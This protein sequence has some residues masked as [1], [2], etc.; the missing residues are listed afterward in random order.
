MRQV[1]DTTSPAANTRRI[2]T[3][4]KRIFKETKKESEPKKK[5]GKK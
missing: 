4:R 2:P 5:T 3:S 1:E